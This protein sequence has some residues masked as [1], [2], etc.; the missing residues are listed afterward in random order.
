MWPRMAQKTPLLISTVRET[1]WRWGRRQERGPRSKGLETGGPAKGTALP[2]PELW[3]GTAAPGGGLGAQLQAWV[4]A[5]C[6]ELDSSQHKEKTAFISTPP[7]PLG[8]TSPSLPSSSRGRGPPP[9]LQP[10]EEQLGEGW[11]G[12]APL[13]DSPL[14]P[15]GQDAIGWV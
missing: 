2:S 9:P 10:G 4:G 11:R 5:G 14:S 13:R 6:R 3:G 8:F 15:R 7:G 12:E 1:H